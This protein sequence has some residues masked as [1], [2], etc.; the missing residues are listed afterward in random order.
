MK[1]DHT[2]QLVV[3]GG[4]AAGFFGALSAAEAGVEKILILEANREVLQKVRISGGG[5]CNVT[6]DCLEPAELV[7]H[8]PRGHRSLRGPFHHFGPRETIDWF[9]ERGVDLKVEPDGRMFP[10]TDDSQ[11]IID[12]LQQETD[13]AGIEVQTRTRVSQ[14]I[15]LPDGGFQLTIGNNESENTLSTSH[16][17]ISA[18]GI[19]NRNNATWLEELGHSITPPC[20]SLFTFKI[21]HPLL[22]DLSGISVPHAIAQACR[23]KQEGPLLITHWG[24]SGPAIL[25]LS[26]W[27]ARDLAEIDYRFEVHLDWTGGQEQNSIQE[28]LDQQRQQHGKRFVN[29]RSPFRELPSRL[30]ERFC[31]LSD[32]S[33]DL[34]WSQLSKKQETRL[35]TFLIDT[36]LP[37][38]GKSTNKDEFVTCGGIPLKEINLKTFASKKLPGLYFAGEVLDID[39]ITGGFNFQAA[40]TGSHLAGQ[41]IGQSLQS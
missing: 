25:K 16:L 28:T 33:S 19:R 35:S 20:P 31:Q 41:A 27:A 24:L 10:S 1:A 15:P 39:G 12:C 26:A 29:K 32:I 40:W 7:N 38:T 23:N 3:V 6:H 34:T 17:L 2:Y 11:T 30:W 9:Q 5:R 36:R 14:I 18:G 21:D 37:V 8:Y 22:T 13:R 4:G